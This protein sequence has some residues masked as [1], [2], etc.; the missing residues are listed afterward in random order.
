[1]I[2]LLRKAVGWTWLAAMFILAIPFILLAFIG[3]VLF[4]VTCWAIGE[5]DWYEQNEFVPVKKPPTSGSPV[6]AN[7]PNPTNPPLVAARQPD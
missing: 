5:V 2:R 7:G 3:L 6:T 1:M 4:I